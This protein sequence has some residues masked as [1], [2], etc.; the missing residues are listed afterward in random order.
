MKFTHAISL[1]LFINGCAGFW[2]FGEQDD[3]VKV[4]GT[5]FIHNDEPY[6]FVGTNLWYACYLGS[7]SIGGDRARL[8]RELD[9][10]EAMGISNIRLLA[11][12]ER[13]ERK[14][15][16][17]PSI[18]PAPGENDDSLLQGLDFTLAEMAKR[19]MK[20]VLFLTN[21]WE[22]SG[23]MEQYIVWAD[24]V[25]VFDTDL[26][27][28]DKFM[29]FSATFY[30]N[31]RAVSMYHSYIKTI[32]ARKNKYNGRMYRDDPTIMS[33]QLANEPRPGADSILGLSNL[34]HFYRWIEETA[35]LIK[36][37]DTNHLV[38][39]GSEGI[40]GTLQ[41]AE[42]FRSAHALPNIDYL[43]IHL[44]PAIWRWFDPKRQEETYRAGL[45]SSVAYI[46]KHFPIARSVNKPLILEEFGIVRD[47]A[48]ASI[49]HP[50]SV[51][52]N[53]YE[54]ILALT[55]DSARSGS[56]IAGTNFWAWGGE[57]RT[58][59]LDRM[60]KEG[61][62]FT[63]DP[64]HEPQGMHSVFDTDRSTIAIIRY[65][66]KLMKDLKQIDT[67]GVKSVSI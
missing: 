14:H 39:I 27:G 6:Y 9:S 23:G 33:W 29:D 20:A 7:P 3:F 31:E 62:A 5:Q 44:W 28:W 66:A 13:S 15:T 22:W 2:P 63:G 21:Y 41:S 55:Y 18:T 51:R 67:M 32:L 16:L 11:G 58:E 47:G 43:T 40:I 54:R 8:M 10:L 65:F 52:D 34:P 17:R 61:D 35:R 60:W 45:D 37:L 26:Y 57:G 50:V 53:F 4:R 56:P 25:P 19:K 12:S 24:S 30:K 42:H 48:N 1:L 38:S 46:V 49:D 64:P 36:S 59:N